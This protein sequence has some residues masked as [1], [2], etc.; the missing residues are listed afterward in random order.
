MLVGQASWP[1][2]RSHET[3]TYYERRLPHWQPDGAALFVTWRL[4]G[5][6][7]PKPEWICAPS[8]G[9]VFAAMDRELAKATT[10]PCWLKDE[11][12][13]QCVVETL[14]FG[15]KSLHLY[16]LHAWVLMANHVHILIEPAAELPRITRSVKNFSARRA[17]EILERTG[18]PFWQDE[19]F[20]R[21]VRNQKEFGKIAQY[22]E[23]NP[24]AAGLA[25]R[26]EDWPWSSA[27]KGAPIPDS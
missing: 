2:Q 19:S 10:G 12:I 5:S 22:I 3:V 6:L 26:P 11:R 25:Q 15:Q 9:K 17:N 1:A 4:Y 23:F 8:S 24:V 13:A 18:K 21:W 7:P 27:Y 20:D 16:D 14:R